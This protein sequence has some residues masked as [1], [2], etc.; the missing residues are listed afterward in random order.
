MIGDNSP[1]I[2]GVAPNFDSSAAGMAAA[3]L[4][5]PAVATVA[6]MFNWDFARTQTVLTPTGNTAPLPWAREYVYPANCVQ[7]WQVMPGSLLDP[8]NPSPV[9]WSVGN[10][11]VSGVE[12][13][14]VWTDQASAVAVYNSN[15]P[16]STWDSL[17]REVV[18]RL[19]SSNM[20]MALAGRPDTSLAMLETAFAINN[21]A[22]TRGS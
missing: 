22:E 19:L 4:Y 14:V 10:A 2:T 20:A 15:P 11:L 1:P 9:N 7:I 8:N 17:F 16:E 18:V 21:I 3:Q 6:R 12:S 5:A 13:R